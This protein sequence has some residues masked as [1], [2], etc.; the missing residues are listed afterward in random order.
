MRSRALKGRSHTSEQAS[1]RSR[2]SS[3]C[4]SLAAFSRV[5]SCCSHSFCHFCH[6]SFASMSRLNFSAISSSHRFWKRFQAAARF[7]SSIQRAGIRLQVAPCYSGLVA[8]SSRSKRDLHP[9]PVDPTGGHHHVQSSY[10][11]LRSA[12]T[13]HEWAATGPAMN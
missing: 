4:T 8:Y 2:S 9:F 1:L 13:S 5:R 7:F 12:R 6:C 11:A 10:F 3:R